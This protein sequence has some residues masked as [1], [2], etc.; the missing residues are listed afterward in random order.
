MAGHT[1]GIWTAHL[2]AS[3][4]IV[5]VEL[6]DSDPKIMAVQPVVL[7]MAEENEEANA[8]FIATAPELL[9]DCIESQ[10]KVC[11]FLCKAH[12]LYGKPW[13]C[14]LCRRMQAT[15]AKAKGEVHD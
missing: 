1:M 12:P 10:D 5:G 4:W 8:H 9:E 6:T 3:G 2:L 7:K 13:H 11:L 14:E 15:I